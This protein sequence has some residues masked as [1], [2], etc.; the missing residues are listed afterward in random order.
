MFIVYEMFF[1]KET[2]PEA[3]VECD[4]FESRFAESYMELYNRAFHP[5]REALGIRPYD[6]YS[7]ISAIKAKSDDIYLLTEGDELIGSVACYGNEIDD[8]FVYEK[9]LMKGYGRQMLYWAMN[10]LRG[11]GYKEIVLHVAEWN[12]HALK[13]YLDAGFEIRKKE[14]INV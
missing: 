5:M 3:K 10:Y 11:K 14:Q 8:L 1:D 4:I 9:Y 12:D 7:D 2:I 13:M 6:W